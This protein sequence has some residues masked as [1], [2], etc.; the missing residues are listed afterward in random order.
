MAGKGAPIGNK[1]AANNKRPWAEA[2]ARALELHKPADKRV[3]LDALAKSLVA[4][5]MNGDISALKEIGDRL[6]GKS[7]QQVELSQDPDNPVFNIEKINT[8]MPHLEATQI[9][10][11]SIKSP[12]TH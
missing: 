4:E 12:A 3:H 7:K 5:A 1:Y 2:I 8:K 9:Y 6:D 11:D 10:K